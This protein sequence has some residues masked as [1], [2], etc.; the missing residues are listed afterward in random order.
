VTVRHFVLATAGH[1]DHGKSALIKSL[2]GTDPDRLPEEKA[3]GITIELGF[4]HLNLT[5]PRG[6]QVVAGIVDVPGHE[7]FVRN[8]IAGVGSIDLALLVVAADD[9]WMPQTEEHLQILMYL[10]VQ[11]LIVALTKSD[12]GDPAVV[13]TQ[14]QSKLKGTALE[15]A[16]IVATS[17]RSGTGIDELKRAVAAILASSPDP[18]DYGKPRLFIDRAF[19]LHGIGTVVTGTLAG[20]RLQTGEIVN[21]QPRGFAARIRSLQSYGKTIAIVRPGMRAAVNLP[22]AQVGSTD[23]GVERGHIATTAGLT[24]SDTLDVL[25][26]R[27][28]RLSERDPAARPLKNGTAVDVHHGT[29]RIAA[30]MVLLE[31]DTLKRGEQA[32]AQLRLESPA[33]AFLGDRLVVRDRSQQQ[34]L[35]GAIVLDP[36]GRRA[37][38]RNDTQKHFLKKRATGWDDLNVGLMSEMER[39]RSVLL[40]GLLEKS[41]FGANEISDALHRLA[42]TG[43]IVLRDKIAISPGHWQELKNRATAMIAEAH[44]RNPERPGLELRT[45]RAAFA[46]EPAEIFDALLADLWTAGFA[47]KGSVIARASHEAALPDRLAD[48]A[49]KILQTLAEKP[50]D[51]P[52]LKQLAPAG[53]AREAL[54][55]LIQS[56]A[57]VDVSAELVLR[58]EDFAR[59]KESIAQFITRNGP[60]T[61]SALRQELGTSRRVIV[62]LLERLD[63]D[64]FTRRVGDHR[65]LAHS[66]VD[67]AIGGIE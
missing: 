65:I 15:A 38:F 6:D 3:R 27:S 63:R 43:A 26:H 52:P 61:V 35:A 56:N 36:D 51:P 14:V 66:L 62:P 13:T 25:I 44:E 16:P 47:Q 30:K 21:I 55:F 49:R 50:V 64:G 58:S 57:L 28:S 53:T 37:N 10:G 42:K 46:D 20:G 41:H 8:M 29:A 40:D 67:D 9:G 1:V 19:S 11:R 39:R 48:V 60:A 23:R 33:C 2:T 45:L 32:I 22:D 31:S 7:D 17:A 5:T 12:L 18:R 59:A 54:K 34:T 4:A 24:M